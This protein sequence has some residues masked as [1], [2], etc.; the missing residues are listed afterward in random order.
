MYIM[1]QSV[2]QKDCYL[3]GRIGCSYNQNISVSTTSFE[4]LIL[5][6]LH[7]TLLDYRYIIV[8]VTQ[9]ILQKDWITVVTVK[10]IAK[11][12][13]FIECL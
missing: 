2:M 3:Q 12:Q 10:V 4:L 1:N 7:V 8:T 5:L 11:V 13:H 9:S 6:H